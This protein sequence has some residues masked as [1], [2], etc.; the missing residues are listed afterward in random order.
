VNATLDL[1]TR[2]RGVRGAMLVSADDGLVIAEQLMEGIKGGAVAALAAS[3][4]GRLRRAMEAA[5]I[6]TSV[7]WHLQA[8]QGALLVVPGNS[9]GTEGGGILVV[10]VAEPDVN[11]GLVRLELLRA[12]EAAV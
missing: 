4:A 5:G 12:A 11:I 6:G 7:F 2:V 10:A 9:G 3:L 1:V 8:E